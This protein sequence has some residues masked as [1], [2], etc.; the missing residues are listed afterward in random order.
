MK[1]LKKT[2]SNKIYTLK[3][4]NLVVEGK[5][6]ERAYGSYT[7]RTYTDFYQKKENGKFRIL[8]SEADPARKEFQNWQEQIESVK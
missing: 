2:K 7:L 1:T 8:F 4:G 5:E 3:N 6:W